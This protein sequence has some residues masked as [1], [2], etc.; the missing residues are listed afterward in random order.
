MRVLI[1]TSHRNLVGGVE[2]YVQTLIPALLSRGH[3]VGLL[4]QYPVRSETET[5]DSRE[6]GLPG[7]CSAE[8][9]HEAALRSLADWGPD[10]VYSQGLEDIALEN[11]L[12]SRYPT[13][14]Y[15][16]TYLGTCISGRKCHTTPQIRPCGRQFGPQCLVLYYPRRCGGLHPGT[17]W[18]MFRQQ[19]QRR[20]GFVGYRTVLVASRHMR[21]EYERHG[22]PRVQLLALP[23]TGGIPNTGAPS[24]RVPAGRILFVGRLVD[25]KGAC[26]LIRA[27]PYAAKQLGCRLTLTVAGDGPERAQVQNLA[28]QLNV[29]VVFSGWLDAQ[30]KLDVMRQSDLLAVPSLWPEP[31]GLVGIEAG[32]LGVP[33]AG[34]AV[35]GIPD[36]LIPG[37]TGEL[38]PGDPPT[39]KGL[40]E[41]IVRTLADPDHYNRLRQGA[42][43]KSKQFT[44]DG[45]VDGL[46]RVLA[47]CAPSNTVTVSIPAAVDS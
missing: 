18:R 17:M 35:G 13:V 21:R 23:M 39:S 15:A 9:G 16:H 12:P 38:A 6:Q 43:A 37:E 11:A 36:W 4:H 33:A 31:F 24:P 2:K 40:A 8:L 1:A 25:V 5:V 46:E 44:L 20:A 22:A 45:H 26:H 47:A 3:S 14:L 28:K 29:D 41:A 30:Q 10:V 19:S 7:W 42:W 34:Y 27:I 32:S